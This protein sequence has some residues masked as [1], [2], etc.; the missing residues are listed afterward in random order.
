MAGTV[1]LFL[2]VPAIPASVVS[3]WVSLFSPLD[4]AVVEALLEGLGNPVV[5][6]E[7]QIRRLIPHEPLP[8]VPLPLPNPVTGQL[9]LFPQLTVVL[10]AGPEPLWS[11]ASSPVLQLPADLLD[12][13]TVQTQIRV[14]KARGGT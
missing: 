4:R 2:P 7:E 6:R 1:N 9:D 3:H 5:G 14:A 12:P 8:L 13:A 10:A 11:V